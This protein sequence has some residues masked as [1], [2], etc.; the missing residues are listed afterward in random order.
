MK[1]FKL[2]LAFS[3]LIAVLSFENSA[4]DG[5]HELLRKLLRHEWLSHG[6]YNAGFSRRGRYVWRLC[7]R[8][9]PIN[10]LL[11]PAGL[12]LWAV[13]VAKPRRSI[14]SK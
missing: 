6:T 12:A 9:R 7:Y 2:N 1:K 8:L 11:S 3:A 13:L 10:K 14:L 4:R 5:I